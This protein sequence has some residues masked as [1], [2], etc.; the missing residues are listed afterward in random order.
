[1]N[2]CHNKPPPPYHVIQGG[3]KRGRLYPVSAWRPFPQPDPAVIAELRA[4]IRKLEGYASTGSREWEGTAGVA[5]AEDDGSPTP[6]VLALGAPQ[7]DGALPWGGLPRGALH[8]I[9]GGGD[10]GAAWGFSAALLARLAG[11]VGTTVV[12]CH[13]R[14]GLYGP[15]LA[16][17]GLGP[18]RL[19]VVRGGTDAEVLWAMEEGLRSGGPAAVLGEARTTTPTAARRLQLAAETGGVTGLLLRFGGE[20]TPSPALTR[21]RI[22]AAPSSNPDTPVPATGWRVELLRCRGGM[23]AAWLVEWHDGTTGGFTVVADLRHGSADGSAQPAAR[24]GRAS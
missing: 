10:D 17:F 16:A 24:A 15:G 11:A 1:M 22:S 4:R 7:I 6:A 8:E 14:D 12:W 20:M 5:A 13:R 19:I 21:W 3:A 23:P 9:A 2:F 18:E